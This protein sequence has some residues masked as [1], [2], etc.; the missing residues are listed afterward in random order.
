MQYSIHCYFSCFDIT[1]YIYIYILFPTHLSS[2]RIRKFHLPVNDTP[3]FRIFFFFFLRYSFYMSLYI[4]WRVLIFVGGYN[5]VWKVSVTL[6]W[7][8]EDCLYVDIS[9]SRSLGKLIFTLSIGIGN[10]CFSVNPYFESRYSIPCTIQRSI[11][12][13]KWRTAM[14]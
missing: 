8:L 4:P 14:S 6:S 10:R 12:H 3:V 13:G 9:D 7:E 11:D 2:S 5:P 1:I